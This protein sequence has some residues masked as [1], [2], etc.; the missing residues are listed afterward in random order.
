ML[1]LVLL[2]HSVVRLS[3]RHVVDLK[4]LE[5]GRSRILP[6]QCSRQVADRKE[7]AALRIEKLESENLERWNLGEGSEDVIDIGRSEVRIEHGPAALLNLNINSLA[8]PFD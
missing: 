4:K 8:V 5:L 3:E 1:S 2:P 6:S 7:M